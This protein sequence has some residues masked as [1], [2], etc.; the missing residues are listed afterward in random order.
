MTYPEIAAILGEAEVGGEMLP[1]YEG[2]FTY[3]QEQRQIVLHFRHSRLIGKSCTGLG[4][5]F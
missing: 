5:W 4:G 2:S 1:D 3:R